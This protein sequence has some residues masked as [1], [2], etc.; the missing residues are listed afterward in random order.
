VGVGGINGP[1][2]IVTTLLTLDGQVISEPTFAGTKIIA[3]S[4]LT[5]F[6][7]YP[8]ET[9]NTQEL[10]ITNEGSAPLTL[11]F[12]YIFPTQDGS[13]FNF[14]SFEPNNGVTP[15]PIEPG[16]TGTLT[17]SYTAG[18]I[19]GEYYNW[20]VIFT[21]ADNPQYKVVT[22]Q[23]I[24]N[25]LNFN[26]S[27]NSFTTTTNKIGERSTV[28]YTLV[29][30]FNGVE[31][32]SV[33]IPFS[34]SISGDPAWKILSTAT[35]QF[36]VEFESHDV[37]NSTGTYVAGV[38]VTSGDASFVVNNTA[39]VEIPYAD[40]YN[41]TKWA[42][43]KAPDNSVI[44]MS[45]DLIDGRKTLTIG[46]GMGGD[47]TPVYDNGGDIFYNLNTLGV[48]ANNL[49]F[50]YS[51][52]AE[53]YRF[54]DLGTGTAKTLL[55]GVVD[56]D[57]GYLYRQKVTDVR[58]YGN[59]FGQGDSFGSMFTID[60]LGTGDVRVYINS[61]RESSGDPAFDATLDNLTRAFHYYS[62]IDIGGRIENF[63]QYP[64]EVSPA[65]PVINSTLPL[66]PGE[67]RTNMFIGFNSITTTTYTVVTSLV[68][69]PS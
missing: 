46:V 30:I 43:P 26:I 63:V 2:P 69:I 8:G 24:S 65:Y 48:G 20:F 67:T 31:T 9:S 58:D 68:D 37:N 11:T 49:D 51:G 52:W 28:T 17:I 42:S 54:T 60:D 4:S 12:P 40:N 15:E 3:V 45:Y 41:F 38:T 64:I 59:Y 13:T 22:K 32:S 10:L 44:G 39:N 16:N 21:D 7:M 36:T 29:P 57:G 50:P 1:R 18:P 25:D 35:N 33:V 27:P 61:I 23:V 14:V 6:L 53:V 5:D 62:P 56:S 47:N 66:P 55:S 19:T 34:L